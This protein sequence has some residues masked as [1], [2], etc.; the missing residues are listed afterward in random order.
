MATYTMQSKASSPQKAVTSQPVR[1]NC[2]GRLD[3]ETPV[4]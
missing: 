2:M 1:E 4:L 3:I